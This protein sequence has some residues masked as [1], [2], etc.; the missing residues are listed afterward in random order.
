LEIQATHHLFLI[1]LWRLCSALYFRGNG[2]YGL[3]DKGQII[4]S[5]FVWNKLAN[6]L[7]IEAPLGSGLSIRMPKYKNK[8]LDLESEAD[9]LSEFL[10]KFFAQQ[11]QFAKSELIIF[12]QAGGGGRPQRWFRSSSKMKF[13]QRI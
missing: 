10:T 1:R 9:F 12:G 2:P 5:K 4:S 7:F 8:Y 11:T 13:Y 6:L 3:N